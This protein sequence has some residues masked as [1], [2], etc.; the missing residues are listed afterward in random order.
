MF[1]IFY[2]R[3]VISVDRT[4][5][6]G[7][8]TPG[9]TADEMERSFFGRLREGVTSSPTRKRYP[10]LALR[11]PGTYLRLPKRVRE[12]QADQQAWYERVL[13]QLEQGR[14]ARDVFIEAERQ[15]E[16]AFVVHAL[17][18]QIANVGL[19][20]LANACAAV[21]LDGLELEIGTAGGPI[22]E[23]DM[24]EAMQAT[25]RGELPLDTFL[26]RYGYNGPEAFEL[27]GTSWRERPELVTASL[28]R[29]LDEA[30]DSSFRKR[31]EASR[32]A[33][34]QLVG[35][36]SRTQRA[37][38][39]VAV[40]IVR[41]YLPM[42]ETGKSLFVQVFDVIRAATRIWGRQLVDEGIL[43]APGDILLLTTAELLRGDNLAAIAAVRA[44]QRREYLGLEL[45]RFFVGQPTPIPIADRT[46][47]G[48]AQAITGVAAS[49]GIAE[50]VVRVVLDPVE[51][52]LEPGEILVCPV[53]DPGWVPLMSVAA[54]LVI[55][56]G[57][58]MSHGAIIAREFG[59]PCV[60]GTDIGTSALKTG[61]RVRI[62]GS[63]GTVTR[64]HDTAD[65]S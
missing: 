65:V 20:Q 8:R 49:S 13:Q 61:D 14:P 64:L 25:A 18:T 12:T 31:A 44:E 3:P 39:K 15:F 16:R 32:K 46:E 54:G 43:E 55:D 38:A 29:I 56:S 19:K 63:T 6:I 57:S 27:S 33:V 23:R 53:T 26:A 52:D 9:I 30:V 7:D 5:W 47:V 51:D 21:G 34:E 1:G 11:A 22:V 41:R 40:A 10:A 28:D 42:R 58:A 62:D 35:T 17:G 48:T 37:N 24:I 60:I 45:P 36:G 4:R 2:G 50:G 59:I